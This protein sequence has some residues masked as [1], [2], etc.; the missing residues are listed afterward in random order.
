MLAR[1]WRD[2]DGGIGILGTGIAALAA[3]FGALAIDASHVYVEQNKLQTTV[4]D[5]ALA[6][7][8]R[9]ASGPEAARRQ[10]R[11]LAASSFAIDEAE[12]DESTAIKFGQQQHGRSARGGRLSLARPA[13]ARQQ[14]HDRRDLQLYRRDRPPTPSEL[15]RRPCAQHGL[16]RERRAASAAPGSPGTRQLIASRCFVG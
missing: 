5:I 2:R 8:Q 13:R 7:A 3:G 12:L 4:D 16:C 10:A 9:L 6:A 1:L 15:Q 11:R 14:Q